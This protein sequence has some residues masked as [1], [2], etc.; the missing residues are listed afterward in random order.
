[1][2]A[3]PFY[4]YV[5]TPA[6]DCFLL[7]DSFE[8]LPQ[9]AAGSVDLVL[10][11][12]PYYIGKDKWD[13]FDGRADYLDFMGRAFLGAERILRD[14]GTLAFWHNDLVK[15]SWLVEWLA[16]HTAFTLNSWAV[17]VK[18]N[19]RRKLWLNPGE[20]NT[21]RS[22]F[23]ICEFLVV[24][25]KTTLGTA[26][27][28]TGL[29]L[30]KLD[31]QNFGTLRDYFRQAQEYTGKS[32]RDIIAACGQ[33]ADH[34]FR[35]NSSQWSLPTRETYLD[36]TATY[37]LTNW[38]GYKSYDELAAMQDELTAECDQQIQDVEAHRY[39]HNLDPAHCN[40]WRSIEPTTGHSIHS[41][42][43]PVD[44]LERI[45]RTH[46]NPGDTVCDFFAGSGSTG[47]AAVHTGRH[48][49]L[50]ERE[51]R[52]QQPGAAWIA[53]EKNKAKP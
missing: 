19:F 9:I 14:N 33:A 15:L 49:I 46:T 50:I 29:A 22:W 18:P 3:P 8:L 6:P 42:Q 21:L 44:L 27:N 20:N 53:A 47:V 5:Q 4:L 43:K 23:N 37:Q 35:W 51:A 16:E 45:I 11:D 40:V 52:Y 10:L 28:K 12:P 24:F 34:C 26:W 17:W 32:K 39:V 41:C 36:I 13:N 1:M 38:G 25:V 31:L 30:A 48:Y 7:G 2:T